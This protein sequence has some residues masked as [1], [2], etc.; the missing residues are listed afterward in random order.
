M[1]A[2][3][4]EK[5]GFRHAT[6]PEFGRS[7]GSCQLAGVGA[8][9]ESNDFGT[10]EPAPIAPRRYRMAAAMGSVRDISLASALAVAINPWGHL[11]LAK[12]PRK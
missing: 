9:L 11:G 6:R 3:I 12:L 7:C 4:F 5:V 2:Q 1:F 10:F 8:G